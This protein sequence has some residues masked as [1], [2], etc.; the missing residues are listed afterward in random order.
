MKP[1]ILENQPIHEFIVEPAKYEEKSSILLNSTTADEQEQLQRVTWRKS[2]FA[3]GF[4]ANVDRVQKLVEKYGIQVT[5]LI[6]G[7]KH[8][9]SASDYML[10]HY[11]VKL[12][13]NNILTMLCIEYTDYSGGEFRFERD[14]EK[15]VVRS[16]SPKPG[17][18]DI[19]FFDHGTLHSVNEVLDGVRI[20][21]SFKVIGALPPATQTDE[22]Q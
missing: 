7:R 3:M 4:T 9:Y 22:S 14:G 2:K 12:G 20:S 5:D 17:Y 11:D 1:I 19:L 6:G 18:G 10:P 15:G 8:I 21:Y 13:E 16:T